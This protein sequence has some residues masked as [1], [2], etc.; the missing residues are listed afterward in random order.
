MAGNVNSLLNHLI[1]GAAVATVTLECFPRFLSALS[2]VIFLSLPRQPFSSGKNM[3]SI[4][5]GGSHEEL[6]PDNDLVNFMNM[7]VTV[8]SK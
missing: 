6:R 8:Y 2:Y 4:A 5:T 3:L 7:H 1:N